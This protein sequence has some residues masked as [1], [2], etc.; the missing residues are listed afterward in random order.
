MV[1]HL[2]ILYCEEKV[3]DV[4]D[5]E[6][7]EE[8]IVEEDVISRFLDRDGLVGVPDHAIDKHTREGKVLGRD[9]NHFFEVGSLLEDV[10]EEWVELDRM[11]KEDAMRSKGY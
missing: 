6:V 5:G 11:I 2:L 9:M 10:D 3:P 8:D 7:N 4:V 1:Q